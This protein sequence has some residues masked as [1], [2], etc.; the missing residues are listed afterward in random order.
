VHNDEKTTPCKSGLTLRRSPAVAGTSTTTF[1]SLCRRSFLH[2][3]LSSFV[4]LLLFSPF[5]LFSTLSLSFCLVSIFSGPGMLL[6]SVFVS[7][8]SHVS[9]VLASFAKGMGMTML[10]AMVVVVGGWCCRCC[11]CWRDQQPVLCLDMDQYPDDSFRFFIA[12]R[13]GWR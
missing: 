2:S 10:I 11:C 3:F 5:I 12:R 8:R 13:G 6:A 9:R 1:A 4:S 7:L